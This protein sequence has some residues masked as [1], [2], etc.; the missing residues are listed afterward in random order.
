MSRMSGGRLF[1]SPLL[2]SYLVC[3]AS[4]FLHLSPHTGG[5]EMDGLTGRKIDKRITHG[6][7]Q[8]RIVSPNRKKEAEKIN[9]PAMASMYTRAVHQD[10][11]LA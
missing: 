1:F 6:T 5:K 9:K 8:Q 11:M 10:D 4:F 3:F 2:L 7:D